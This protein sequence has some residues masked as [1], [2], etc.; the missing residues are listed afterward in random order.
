MTASQPPF[1]GSVSDVAAA[2]TAHSFT[3]ALTEISFWNL[4]TLAALVKLV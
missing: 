2:G 3:V 4:G 1:N